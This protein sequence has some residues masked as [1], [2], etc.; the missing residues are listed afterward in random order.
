MPR[1]VDTTA[2]LRGAIDRGATGDK[3]GFPDPAAT[4]LGTDDEAAGTPP[5]AEAVRQAA[6]TEIRRADAPVR[7]PEAPRSLTGEGGGIGSAASGPAFLLAGAILA[8]GVAII[9]WLAA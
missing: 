8:V 4:P 5:S 7:S 9:L 1:E 2:R 3:I 6:S